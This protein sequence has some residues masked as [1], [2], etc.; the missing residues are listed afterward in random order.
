MA[1]LARIDGGGGGTV[2]HLQALKAPPW[3]M[4][5]WS[6]FSLQLIIILMVNG[7]GNKLILRAIEV[8]KGQHTR[9]DFLP[10]CR[11]QLE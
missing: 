11:M 6:E 4:G 2:P 8:S 9:G 3:A 1:K 7:T 10:T 5:I